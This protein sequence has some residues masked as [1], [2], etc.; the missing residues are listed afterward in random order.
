MLARSAAH[1]PPTCSGVFAQLKNLVEQPTTKSSLAAS[2]TSSTAPSRSPSTSSPAQTV[3]NYW[4]YFWTLLP[5]HLTERDS[6]GFSQRVSL[7]ATPQGTL[8]LNLD[9]DGAGPCRPS[10]RRVPGEARPASRPPA[11]RACRPTAST[12]RP[13]RVTP[14]QFDPHELPILHAQPGRPDRAERLRLPARSDRLRARPAAASPGQCDENPAVVVP[15]L[16]GDRGITDVFWKQDGTRDLQGHPREGEAAVRGRSASAFPNWPIGADRVRGPR[17]GSYL[18]FTKNVPGAAGPRSRA[19]FNSAQN[20]RPNSPV[21]IAGVEVGKV[22]KVEPLAGSE[23][24]DGIES[25]RRTG[26]NG[27]GAVVTM[28]IDDEGLPLKEDATLQAE[29]APLPRGQPLRRRQPGQPVGA[30]RRRRLRLP[31]PAD[32]EHGPAR[33]GP[34]RRSRPTPAPTSRSSSTSSAPR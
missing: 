1:E 22:T 11:T 20:L 28:E 9:L 23:D 33:P 31:A 14:G 34:D 13:T 21:R 25:D 27:S 3:C 19:V 15:D 8:T 2:A 5:E 10:R 26:P 6:I 17:V 16:P 12:G 24:S 18:A 30:G 32:V 4:N 29:A 7:I